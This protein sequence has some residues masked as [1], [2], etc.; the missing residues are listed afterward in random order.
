MSKKLALGAGTLVLD[1][2]W[3]TGAFRKTLVE[4]RELAAA[5]RQV[6]RAG[7]CHPS[8]VLRQIRKL[9]ARRDDPCAAA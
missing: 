9:E 1:V 7:G 4:A 6:A 5:L 2:K 3:G 8:T